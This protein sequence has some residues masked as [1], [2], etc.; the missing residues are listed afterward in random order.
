MPSYPPRTDIGSFEIT[1]I[2]DKSRDVFLYWRKIP[3][4][5]ENGENFVYEVDYVEKNGLDAYLRNK[6]STVAFVKYTVA[7]DSKYLFKIA[8]KNEVGFSK[9][10]SELVV[11]NQYEGEYNKKK[12]KAD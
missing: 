5:Y 9:G 12:K 4:N 11:P 2:D 10:R 1:E 8:S 6:N 3:Q 7:T